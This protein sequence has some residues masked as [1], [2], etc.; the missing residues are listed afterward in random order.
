[1]L[2]ELESLDNFALVG[3]GPAATSLAGTIAR[4]PGRLGHVVGVSYRV[5][6][7]IANS[8]GLGTPARDPSVLQDTELI[9]FHA[10]LRQMELLAAQF[11]E[12]KVNW[13]KKNLIFIDCDAG[14]ME[15]APMAEAAFAWITRCPIPGRL[16]VGGQ[17]TALT[18]AT[19]LAA[20]QDRRP[21]IVP[22]TAKQSFEAAMLLGGAAITPLIDSVA[23]ILRG[24]GMLDKQ[25]TQTAVALFQTTVLA[26]G[27]SGRQS[28]QWHVHEPDVDS[29]QA[30]VKSL[31]D[32]E[33]RILRDLLLLGFER[34]QRHEEAA[35]TLREPGGE[36]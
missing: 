2:R 24:T 14:P 13:A 17:G 29:L 9:L 3:A 15:K 7:R 21:L 5:A 20:T 19:R 26:Y 11:A 16:A 22:N 27:R 6:S 23:H 28:W 30:Q 12:A 8:L 36:V 25:A 33:G 35:A 4:L 10:P 34:F 18:A 31:G 1:M 32:R